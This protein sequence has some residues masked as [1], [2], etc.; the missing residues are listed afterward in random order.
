M[1]NEN[2]LSACDPHKDSW[3]PIGSSDASFP[4]PA[5]A[6]PSVTLQWW[7]LKRYWLALAAAA[8]I[9]MVVASVVLGTKML[10][11]GI[12]TL[13]PPATQDNNSNNPNSN[14]PKPA[15]RGAACSDTL[16]PQILS[17]AI[18]G[19]NGASGSS[20]EVFLF[21]RGKDNATLWYNSAPVDSFAS[22]AGWPS[23]QQWNRLRG[24]PFR[25]Q[26]TAVSWK[27]GANV[28]VAAVLESS[29]RVGLTSFARNG[30]G[31][32]VYRMGDFED[33]GG[34]VKGPLATFAL[35]ENIRADWYAAEDKGVAQNVWNDDAGGWSHPRDGQSKLNLL[36]TAF[37]FR[38][39]SR[40]AMICRNDATWFHDL[41]VFGDD[42]VVRHIM[43]RLGQPN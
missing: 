36:E 8:M 32:V 17:A 30:S 31:S 33:L 9:I 5:S 2:T 25:T 42:G 39:P 22:Q 10:S 40:P 28:S 16:C 35:R 4:Q 23:N 1:F 12:Q 13:T 6:S 7:K 18:L 26:P 14:M 19:G 41:V 38:L 24:G 29:G 37:A 11:T 3:A 21:A 27:E 15:P 20:E 34:P 43:Y